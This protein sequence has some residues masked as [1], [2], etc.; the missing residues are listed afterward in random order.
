LTS[1]EDEQKL[2]PEEDKVAAAYENISRKLESIRNGKEPEDE[3]EEGGEVAKRRSDEEGEE[4]ELEKWKGPKGV[5]HSTGSGQASEEEDGDEETQLRRIK[6]KNL[7][8]EKDDEEDEEEDDD[9]EVD[10]DE[11]AKDADEEESKPEKKWEPVKDDPLDEEPAIQ[12]GK[13]SAESKELASLSGRSGA[14][15]ENESEIGLPK[16]RTPQPDTLDDLAEEDYSIPNLKGSR[17]GGYNIGY[18]TPSQKSNMENMQNISAS[19]DP[20]IFFSSHNQSSPPKRANKFHLL[21]L[22]IIGIFVIGFTVY[23]LKGGFG[24]IGKTLSPSP[25]PSEQAS[26]SPTPT[27]TPE[28]ERSKYKVRVLNGSGK[29]GLAKTL[30][31]KL[32]ELG[33]QIDKTGNATNSAFTQTL[34]R[35]KPANESFIP[36]VVKDLAPD[37]DGAGNTSL[38]DD[39]K[40]DIEIILGAK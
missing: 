28:P 30:S 8:S 27:P 22:V 15:D 24:Q 21:I 36:Q 25:S 31:E 29:T 34:I 14:E 37:Y 11:K 10:E 2:S 18:N 9:D 32:K 35:V 4:V 5:T 23:I 38:E 26:P 40:V 39:D 19:N 20:N 17:Q 16:E 1:D 3:E 6:L 12:R 33:Y 7:E 13:E